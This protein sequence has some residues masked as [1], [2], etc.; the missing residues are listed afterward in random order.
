MYFYVLRQKPNDNSVL[1]HEKRQC[2]QM[3]LLSSHF[4]VEMWLVYTA[5]LGSFMTQIVWKHCMEVWSMHAKRGRFFR[6]K[7]VFMKTGSI[8]FHKI[9][10]NDKLNSSASLKNRPSSQNWL[11]FKSHKKCQNRA[12]PSG[13]NRRPDSNI[14]TWPDFF[15]LS[16]CI[17][18][19]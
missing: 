1:Y 16:S 7:K 2:D 13:R 15:S 19:M 11:S 17:I 5:L 12:P 9:T 4:I 8:N 10:A 3:R 18:L 6:F 14:Y